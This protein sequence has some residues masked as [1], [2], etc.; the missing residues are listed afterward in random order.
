M[1]DHDDRKTHRRRVYF[2]A[3]L[4]GMIALAIVGSYVLWE[5][6]S[7][8]ALARA[9][10]EW[11]RAGEP[12]EVGDFAPRDLPDDR[13]A[14]V[15][16]R[17]AAEMIDAK[18]DPYE[19]KD[20]E[21]ELP[22]S[23]ADLKAIETF[24]LQNSAAMA[25]ARKARAMTDA[26]WR[27]PAELWIQLQGT[28]P[29]NP[30]RAV[31]N[32][33]GF[34]ALMHAQ[35]G[36]EVAAIEAVRDIQQHA[37]AVGRITPTLTGALVASAIRAMATDRIEQLAIIPPNEIKTP[38]SADQLRAV[39]AKLLDDSVSPQEW[40]RAMDG[41][42]AM[43]LNFG[44]NFVTK[45]FPAPAARQ[46]LVTMLRT[47]TLLKEIG[48]MTN[49][50]AAKEAMDGLYPE[51][52]RIQ[53]PVSKVAELTYASLAG[54]IKSRMC[55]LASRRMAAIALA[56]QWYAR[57][58]DGKRPAALKEL[59][60]KYLPALPVDPFATDGR[61][62]GYLPDD[63][64]PRVYSVGDNGAD[65]GGSLELLERKSGL[66]VYGIWYFHDA[67]LFLTREGR[68]WGEKKAAEPR[69]PTGPGEPNG[70]TTR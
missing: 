54:P 34:A 52:P 14:A 27:E 49:W 7:R 4:F 38:A 31:A 24:V 6:T 44:R 65:D 69:L 37:D 57:E 36:D 16:Y 22:L 53:T 50:P 70:A 40:T 60:P 48:H 12:L 43:E 64:M 39:I 13:N 25:E 8:R 21:L 51:P 10:D 56:I 29:Y 41:E 55:I 68:R 30:Q 11:K 1:T 66:N 62:F 17:R 67:P 28:P 15:V 3:A 26:E 58:H 5:V 59:V 45:S 63:A 9:V 32:L 42:R 47:T 18:N 46:Q 20:L 61:T 35:Y 23:P 33:F 19:K 2:W